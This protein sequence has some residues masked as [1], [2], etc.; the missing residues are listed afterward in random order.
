MAATLDAKVYMVDRY[1]VSAT[2]S[3]L[4]VEDLPSVVS[5]ATENER[6]RILSDYETASRSVS[7]NL[8]TFKATYCADAS[9]QGI[10][11]I[12]YEFADCTD[13]ADGE[14]DFKA[15]CPVGQSTELT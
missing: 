8:K 15:F 9:F 12:K 5:T 13:N 11:S 6:L 3:T 7:C 10:I 4:S 14:V 2:A 1:V